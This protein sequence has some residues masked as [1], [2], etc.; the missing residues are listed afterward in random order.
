FAERWYGAPTM[1]F[2]GGRLTVVLA[3]WHIPLMQVASHLNH[4][5][6]SRAVKNAAYLAQ[7]LGSA[8]PRIGVCGLNPHAG[9]EG[10]LGYE[11]QG[12]I[13]PILDALRGTYPGLSHCLP[14][15]TVFHRQLQGE[16][17]VI[18]AMYHDQGL[19]PLKALDF[20]RAVNITLG[21][22]FI[23]TSPDHGTAF[24]I[25]GK[26]QAETGSFRRAI[27]LALQLS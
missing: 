11:E 16:F 23:R 6:L 15:D 22:P 3:T 4:E 25:A 7:K 9:E 14:G 13:D 10:L 12:I 26:G 20:D 17:D 18:I 21:L 5:T 1:A 8:N 24:G 19:A 2:A 27:E